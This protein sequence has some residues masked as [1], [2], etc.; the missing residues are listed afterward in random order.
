MNRRDN[1]ELSTRHEI[2]EQSARRQG[3]RAA[4]RR[5]L[6]LAALFVKFPASSWVAMAAGRIGSI[7]GSIAPG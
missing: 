7:I 4:V 3:E 5:T 6:S 1:S 2:R